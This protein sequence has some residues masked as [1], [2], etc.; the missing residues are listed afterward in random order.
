MGLFDEW[1]TRIEK[2]Y[3]SRGINLPYS[4]SV[5]DHAVWTYEP[6]VAARVTKQMLREAKVQVW[7]RRYLQ[8]VRKNGTRITDL[9]TSGGTFNAGLIGAGGTSAT[10]PMNT[11]GE[12]TYVCTVAGHNMTGFLTVNP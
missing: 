12:F 1:H 11:V 10:I 4:V 6:H 8:T 3:Q 7:T 5:K 2:D 9:V